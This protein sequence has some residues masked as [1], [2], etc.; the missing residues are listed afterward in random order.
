MAPEVIKQTGYDYRADI[1][2]LGITAIEMAKGE[3]PYADCHPMR[4]LF[5]IPK[6]TPPLLEGPFSKA[7]KEFVSLCLAKNPEERPPCKELLKHRFV[8]AAKKTSHL[9][10]LIERYQRWKENNITDTSTEDDV[11]IDSKESG[12]TR[13]TMK[14]D[15]GTVRE[16][17]NASSSSRPKS[18]INL[19]PSAVPAAVSARSESPVPRVR[20]RTFGSP[21]SSP[22]ID[23]HASSRLERRVPARKS[24]STEEA[25]GVVMQATPDSTRTSRGSQERLAPA[26]SFS[27]VL[28]TVVNPAIKHA[29]KRTESEE[30]LALLG[31]LGLLFEEMDRLDNKRLHVLLGEISSNYSRVTGR[32]SSL[33][34]GYESGTMK[35]VGSSSAQDRTQGGPQVS[36]TTAKYIQDRWKTKFLNTQVKSLDL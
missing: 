24:K 35:R 34:G 21:T 18:A 20:D 3:P 2:S 7:F 22:R 15:F 5:L 25:A 36:S 6:N 11:T 32:S 27:T 23:A 10:D 12:T 14:W 13:G 29:Q 9:V 16:A 19:I 8:K 33:T 26:R 1:W 17:P 28:A 31:R 4:V 30:M